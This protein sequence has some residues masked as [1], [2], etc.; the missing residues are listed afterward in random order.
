MRVY[1]HALVEWV[2]GGKIGGG[3]WF[4]NLTFLLILRLIVKPE[5]KFV[6]FLAKSTNRNIFKVKES[7]IIISVHDAENSLLRS[8]R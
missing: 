6:K 1:R 3:K 8:S 5:S 2:W 4:E 7:C